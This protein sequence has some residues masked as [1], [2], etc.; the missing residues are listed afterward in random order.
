[1]GWNDENTLLL[2]GMT[3]GKNRG[4]CRRFDEM[5]LHNSIGGGRR[6]VRIM[7]PYALP[8]MGLVYN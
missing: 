8:L 2:W 3:G 4:F 1:V 7:P 6:D 5:M